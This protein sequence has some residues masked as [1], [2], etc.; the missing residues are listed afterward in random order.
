[1]EEHP[2]GVAVKSPRLVPPSET[3]ST[4]KAAVPVFEIVTVFGLLVLLKGC[5][6]KLKAVG[7]ITP[8]AFVEPVPRSVRTNGLIRASLSTIRVASRVPTRAGLNAIETLHAALGAITT[9]QPVG[10][11]E[12]SDA[13]VPATVNPA[14]CSGRSPMFVRE[15]GNGDPVVPT[16]TVPNCAG[17]GFIRINGASMAV[18]AM[19]T[20]CGLS[21]AL[22]LRVSV[23]DFIPTDDA[24][25]VIVI[26]HLAPGA[27]G[28]FRGQVVVRL[29]SVVPV[30]RIEAKVRGALPVFTIATG[31][32][33]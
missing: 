18:A 32:V 14:M 4:E 30:R 10:V 27:M 20:T 29:N 23:A 21:A 22:S 26:L 28:L 16:S 31:L 19:L 33:N 6:P 24:F 8:F 25:T 3:D 13:A 2:L 12:Y 17:A 7:E 9:L 1:M 5:A 15:T 11:A